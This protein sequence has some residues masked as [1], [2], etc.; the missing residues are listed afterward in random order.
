VAVAVAMWLY[1]KKHSSSTK[2]KK[3]TNPKK[4]KKKNTNPNPQPPKKTKNKNC[5]PIPIL[6]KKNCESSYL[7]LTLPIKKSANPRFEDCLSKQSQKKSPATAQIEKDIG[8]TLSDHPLFTSEDGR[9]SL[10]RVLIGA[11]WHFLRV[12]LG[13]FEG[14]WYRN[15]RKMDGNGYFLAEIRE[16]WLKNGRIIRCLQ[17]KMAGNRSKECSSVRFYVFLLCF[18]GVFELFWY[19]NG[20]KMA[21]KDRFLTEIHEKWSKCHFLTWIMMKNVFFY[22]K[23]C[24]SVRFDAL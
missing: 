15:G 8:R 3:L 10:K 20:R 14:F 11:F 23:E 7:L 16:K 24:S 17:V 21:K 5:D 12:F 13:V 18:W 6:K 19:R 9:E 2:N 22:G 4:K 1:I